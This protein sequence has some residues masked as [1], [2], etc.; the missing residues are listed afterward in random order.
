MLYIKFHNCGKESILAACDSELIGR[1]FSD[2][3]FRIEVFP[4]FYRDVCI[5]EAQLVE[6]LSRA[7]IG[8]LVGERAIEVAIQNKF[9]LEKNVIEIS[10]VKHA[11][12]AR[13]L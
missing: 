3:K 2:D 10:G 5:E 7:T 4:E 1:K 6:F 13:K 11:Q 12:F 8:N 9:I